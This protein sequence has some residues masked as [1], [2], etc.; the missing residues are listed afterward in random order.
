MPDLKVT[1]FCHNG[2]E[3]LLNVKKSWNLGLGTRL[4][5]AGIHL[6]HGRTRLLGREMRQNHSRKD[7]VGNPEFLIS[8]F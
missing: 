1:L 3:N 7:T 5:E 6:N 8:P 4:G 2:V